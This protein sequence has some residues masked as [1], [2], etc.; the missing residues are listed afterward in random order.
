MVSRD[1]IAAPEA[2]SA[3]GRGGPDGAVHVPEMLA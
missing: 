2:V 1:R 3:A